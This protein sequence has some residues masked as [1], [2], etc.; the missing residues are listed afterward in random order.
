LLPAARTEVLARR[1][2]HF[3]GKHVSKRSR[4]RR[5]QV[6]RPRPGDNR[7]PA[8][9]TTHATTL[10]AV[11][12]L[13]LSGTSALIYQVLWIKQLSLVV[14]VDVYAVTIAISA[15]F[16]GLGFGGFALG[17][18]ADRV[19][20]PILLYA[21]LEIGVAI[22]GV[23]VTI[24]LVHAAKLFAALEAQ[25]D[26]FAWPPLFALVSAAP[27]LMGGTL[28]VLVRAL[29]PHDGEIG[30]AGGRLYAA[31]TCGA[32]AG[33]LLT[34]FLLIPAVGVQG[35]AFVA[36]A[37][38]LLAAFAAFSLDGSTAPRA[39]TT[40]ETTPASTDARV[41][42][43]LYAIAGGIA[44]G[45]EVVWSQMIAQFI[46]TRS[47]AFAVV[48]AT[49]LAGLVV[50]AIVS[51]R[52]ADRLRDPWGAFGLLI[53]S[54]G[55]FALIEIAALGRWVVVWQSAAEFAVLSLTG[56]DLA[57]MCARFAVA[58]GCIVLVPTILLG[59]AFPIALRLAARAR[60]VGRDVGSVIALNTLGGIFGTIV[61]G[62]VLL[63]ALGLVH[64]LAILTLAAA[65][66][67]VAAAIR[68]PT[69]KR[70]GLVA[71]TGTA[72]VAVIVAVATP[73]DRLASLLAQSRRG[74]LTAYEESA[75]GTVAVIEQSLGQNR[76]R[77]LYIQ[78]V[79]N[80]GDAMPSLRYMRL[81]SLLPLI[82]HPEPRS[83]LVI[84]LGTGITAG[85]LLRYPDLERR[86]VAE[87]LPAVLRAAPN[88]KGNY[89]VASDPRVDI[90]LRDG[91]RELLR[92]TEQYDLITLEPPPPSAAGVVNLYSTDFYTIGRARLRENG[93]LAQWLPLATQND[94]DTRS[95][96]RSFL[97]VFPHASLWSTDF[98]EM[99]L[100]GSTAPL[101]LDVARMVQRL[102]QPE[103]A[104]SLREVGIGSLAS[105]LATWVTDSE[106]LKHYAGNAL[107]VTDDRPRIETAT[108]TRPNEF[109]RV[110]PR[111]LELRS[112][113][114][115]RGA[116]PT[117]L[118]AVS[119]ERERLL[120][121]YSAGLNARTG[122]Q[123]SW[124][125]DIARVVRN[126]PGN[127]YYRW[128]TGGAS[129]AQR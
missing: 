30:S 24:A 88:F 83:A 48:L 111:L 90:R 10:P 124:A 12:L 22:L 78:G 64:T 33:T 96:V 125:R 34:P 79:S 110:L 2:V 114:P 4:K 70:A 49:Y 102:G 54:A 1:E 23:A 117:L 15:F 109:Q 31:N 61:T 29:G 119:T 55:L 100:V 17:R 25:G 113:P 112:D 32:I 62:F 75:G 58:A 11:L 60:Q 41:A 35:T 82:I 123:A 93:I 50:G 127:P 63:P 16:A 20:R 21:T 76:F 56:S 45:Y 95:L 65:L 57:A 68:G 28:P 107:P 5:A 94:E 128:F 80:S 6:S 103:V 92:S 43:I 77:R 3:A 87:L 13:L 115:L 104:E 121:F 18:L 59:A 38:S 126:D 74:T 36:A 73:A 122:Q 71:A 81:Q 40:P 53:A 52:F 98:H 105:L 97:D 99:M 120:T 66:L 7:H 44:L 85:A 9:A 129:S 67:G 27:F 51:A 47:F 19:A 37:I 42:V 91:R 106:G 108:W 8:Q 39:T 14:G 26:W 118:A 89:G 84:G 101:D 69:G 72:V 86:V 46:S 116:D